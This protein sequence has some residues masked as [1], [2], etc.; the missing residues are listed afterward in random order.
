MPPLN[1]YARVRI[2][3]CILHTRPRVQRA[4]GIPC[5]LL[6]WRVNPI[7]TRAH[8]AARPRS[9]ALHEA[10]RVSGSGPKLVAWHSQVMYPQQNI[11]VSDLVQLNVNQNNKY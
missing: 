3:L 5:T 1:L 7:K 2:S 6:F 9:H 4:P 8:C 10:K 11:L